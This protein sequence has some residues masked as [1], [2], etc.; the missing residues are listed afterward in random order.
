MQILAKLLVLG[1]LLLSTCFVSP[2]DARKDSETA[3]V[4]PEAV[5]ESPKERPKQTKNSEAIEVVGVNDGDTVTV[6]FGKNKKQKKIR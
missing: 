4:T 6:L 5:K 2:E 1:A 3:Q